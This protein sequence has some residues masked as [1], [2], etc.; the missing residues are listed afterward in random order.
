LGTAYDKLVAPPLAQALISAVT[1]AGEQLSGLVEC[2]IRLQGTNVERLRLED[3]PGLR[4]GEERLVTAVYLQ[5]DGP[6]EGHVVLSFSP[7]AA[8]Q[9]SEKLLM[10]PVP[11]DEPLSVMAESALGE[12]GNIVT[13][14]FLTAI[15]NAVDYTVH[16]SPPVVIQDMI[17]ALLSNVV[18]EL[19]L[20]S[21]RAL[22][23]HTIFEVG[24]ETLQGELILLP[25]DR[26]CDTLESRLVS[27]NQLPR[28]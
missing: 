22:L 2:S 13:A 24:G 7:E 11:C 3:L 21:T 8:V 18:L 5:F 15:A 17:G 20:D 9:L 6:F 25:T 16:P 4:E 27:C 28:E 19:A 10:E 14:S 23:V 1:Y 26:S 12:V